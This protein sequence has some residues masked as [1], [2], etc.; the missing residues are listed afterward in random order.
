M[1]KTSQTYDWKIV[2]FDSIVENVRESAMPEP[3]DSEHYIGLEHLDS[4][5]LRVKHWGS[6][7]TLIGQKLKMKK[8]DILFA[9]RNAYLR[10]IAIAPHDG[11]FSAHGMIMRPKIDMVHPDFLPFFLVS[12]HFMERAIKI[13]VGSLSPTIN[14]STLKKQE[15]TLP[16]LTEQKRIAKVLWAVEQS[17]WKTEDAIEVV[18]RYRR[19]LMKHLF[20]YGLVSI[21]KARQVNIKQTRI[22]EIP[23]SW[24]VTK[25][26][27]LVRNPITYGIVQA[28][29]HLD[30]GIPYIRSGDLVGGIIDTENLLMTSPEI[31][32]H[33]KRTF[34]ELNDIV[35]P[36]R[37]NIGE[38]ALVKDDAVGVNLS[39]GNAR[40]SPS[41]RCDAHYLLWAI[42]SPQVA[43]EILRRTTGT[44]FREISLKELRK[45]PI[46]VPPLNVQE[47]ISRILQELDIFVNSIE[48]HLNRLDELRKGLIQVL[49]GENTE[50][51]SDV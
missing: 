29:P 44:T 43:K 17:I 12:D 8:G 33:Y 24:N 7:V 50:M 39:R 45:I 20:T 25:L 18:E 35:F 13:S 19:T 10:R 47:Q 11:L 34:V 14:W 38:V 1:N 21:K 30:E 32:A 16:P 42:R 37:G 3:D 5:S 9:R 22:G 41:D 51:K 48:K 15:F 36:L 4:G 23:E 6:D 46:P 31:A 26:E 27:N 49:L 2:R 40:I 28:G